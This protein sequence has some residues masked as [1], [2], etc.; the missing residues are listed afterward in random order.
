MYGIA[1]AK[2]N[3]CALFDER[4]RR[5]DLPS[6]VTRLR[7]SNFSCAASSGLA[8]WLSTTSCLSNSKVCGS[9]LTQQVGA[10]LGVYLSLW[11][12]GRASAIRKYT[13]QQPQTLKRE[14]LVEN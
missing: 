9:V 4:G 7:C 6:Y 13:L 8:V 11:R 14:S 10:A 1:R 2:D 3:V 12:R 5:I